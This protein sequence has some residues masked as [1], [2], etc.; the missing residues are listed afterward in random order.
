MKNGGADVRVLNQQPVNPEGEDWR[1]KIVANARGVADQATE[2]TPLVGYVVVGLY[3][4]GCS[5]VGYRY[6]FDNCPVTTDANSGLGFGNPP[7]R[8][9][10]GHRGTRHFQQHV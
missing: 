7:P 3:A 1:G 9:D 5:S 10:R 4:D 8:H 6:D 2:E